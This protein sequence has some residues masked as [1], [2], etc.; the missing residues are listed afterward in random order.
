MA[1]VG[2]K[3]TIQSASNFRLA[4]EHDRL[5]SSEQGTEARTVT[6]RPKGD[7]HA[8]RVYQATCHFPAPQAICPNNLLPT[9]PLEKLKSPHLFS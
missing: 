6:V 8:R 1:P 4:R 5:V 3:W 7:V 9:I 2:E